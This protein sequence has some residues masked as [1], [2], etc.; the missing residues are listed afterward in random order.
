MRKFNFCVYDK[1]VLLNLTKKKVL[2]CLS[3][4]TQTNYLLFELLLSVENI[5]VMRWKELKVCKIY[6]SRESIGH[7]NVLERLVFYRPYNLT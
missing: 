2:F 5:P 1:I 6:F 3:I 7:L 4:K